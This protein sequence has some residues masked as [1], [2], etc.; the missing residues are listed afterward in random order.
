M[1]K[2]DKKRFK[3]SLKQKRSIGGYL[4]TLPLSLGFILFFL[5]PFIQSV[6]F[7]LSELIIKNDGYSL[8]FL[9][10]NNY[11][12]ALF[13][14]A[15]FV[16]TL[17]E[18]ILKTISDVPMIIGF[19]FFAAILLNEKFRGRMLA[20]EIFFLPVI[21]SAGVILK[22]EQSD[23]MTQLLGS[24]SSQSAGIFFSNEVMESFLMSMKLPQ[25]FLEYIMSAINYIPKIIKSS[26]IQILIFLAGLQSVPS[27]LYEA[28]QV[29]GA[30]GWENFWKITFPLMSPLILVNIVYTIIDSFTAPDNQVIALIKKTSFQGAGYGVGTAM[31]WIYFLLIGILLFITITIISRKIFYME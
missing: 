8:N 22:I 28:S 20:R 23:Y 19:S 29:E 10:F 7:S 4:F 25:G 26:C 6:L 5:Y 3:L 21:Y 17:F 30:T 15:E 12:K 2:G 1:N 27:S 13:V 9:G 24:A 31:A 11:N 16:R 14:N 18:T